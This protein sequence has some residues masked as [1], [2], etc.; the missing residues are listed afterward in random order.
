M[1]KIQARIIIEILG[2]PPEHI[3][4]GIST[5]VSKL[6]LE[7]GVR[8]VEKTIHEP[9]EV[10]DA[11]NIYTTFAEVLLEIDS[12]EILFG[13][14]FGYMPSHIEVIEPEEIKLKN[15]HFN[16]IGNRIVQ[17]LH[18]YDAILKKVLIEKEI[19]EKELREKSS[20]KKK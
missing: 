13:I 4:E 7:K 11:K 10:K 12:V 3:K 8:I 2:R 6:G 17:R 14:I 15:I 1:E 18:D 20:K 9:I 5:L 19:V 16:E